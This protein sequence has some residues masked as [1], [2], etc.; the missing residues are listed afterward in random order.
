MSENI[1]YKIIEEAALRNASD[2]HL[3]SNNNIYLRINGSLIKTDISISTTEIDIFLDKILEFHDKE[4]LEKKIDINKTIKH[5][6]IRIRINIFKSEGKYSLAMRIIPE[7]IIPLDNLGIYKIKNEILCPLK[8]LVVITGISGSGKTTSLHSIID[9]INKNYNYNILTIEDPIEYK[10]SSVNSLINQREINHDIDS[11]E[12]GLISSLR[13]DPDIIVVGEAN[14]LN[15]I[16]TAITAAE[17]G[18]LVITSLH[19]SNCI[20]TIDRLIDVFPSNQQ[21]QIRTQLSA[22]LKMII[23]QQ[24]ITKNNKRYAKFECLL[25]DNAIKNLIRDNKTYLIHDLIEL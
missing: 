10:H 1:I 4:D 9:Y 11:F 2:I 8:G 15:T 12:S 3:K 19:T 24:L 13:E 5:N 14:N 23:S 21:N 18:H 20:D 17:T 22:V 25:V 16:K 6:N 7:K